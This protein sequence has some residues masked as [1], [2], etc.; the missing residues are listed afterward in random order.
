MECLPHET[1][2]EQKRG[3]QYTSLATSLSQPHIQ[4][5]CH[6]WMESQTWEFG[7]AP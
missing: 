4:R 6:P 7:T 5:P 1:L 2:V 3:H